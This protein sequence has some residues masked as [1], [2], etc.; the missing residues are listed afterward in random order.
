[1]LLTYVPPFPIY[2]PETAWMRTPR[3]YIT[4]LIVR[5]TPPGNRI[6]LL[7]AA[8]N[9]RFNKDCWVEEEGY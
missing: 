7:A 6:A 9:G 2:P 4:G 5:T 3:T 1:M 8:L